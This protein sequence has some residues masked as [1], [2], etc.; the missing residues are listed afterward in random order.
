MNSAKEAALAGSQTSSW[1]KTIRL[2]PPEWWRTDSTA[3]VPLS[4]SRAVR[5]TVSPFC[6][7]CLTISNPIP[8]LAPVTTATLEQNKQCNQYK[9]DVLNQRSGPPGYKNMVPTFLDHDVDSSRLPF[10]DDLPDRV[11]AQDF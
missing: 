10:S 3:A 9:E 2:S 7:N 11:L 5:T 8:L 6:S 1:W 4:M